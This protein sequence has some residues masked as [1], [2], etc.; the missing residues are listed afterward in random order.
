MKA[1]SLFGVFVMARLL[2]LAGRT[3]PHSAWALPAYL[4]QDA[5]AALCFAA[6]ELAARRQPWL[7]WC[8]YV[9]VVSYVAVNVPIAC[10]LSTPLTWPMLR[11]ARGTLSDS[12]AHHVTVPNLA[13]ML[14]VVGT[15]VALPWL[16][17]RHGPRL[18]TRASLAL[19]AAA[20]V[21]VLIGPFA[22][23]RVATRAG[24]QLPVRPGDNGPA[25][26]GGGGP[27]RGLAPQPLRQPARRRPVRLPRRRGGAQ[28]PHRS[29]RID[30]RRSPASLRRRPR[31]DAATHRTVSTR[32]GL[33]ERLH[34]L[35]R[36]DQEL[37]RRP[38]CRLSGAR[39]AVGGLRARYCTRRW[40]RRWGRPAT[41]P[42]S[43]I[44]GGSA[45]SVWTP[46]S[47]ARDLKRPR[48]R[49]PSAESTIPVSA[50]TSRP[51]SAASCAGSTSVRRANRS[52]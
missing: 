15:A 8:A 39:R 40:R 17:R 19:V 50:S 48:T 35:P 41:T 13:R 36:D 49:G 11:A 5:L 7:A 22:A 12:I 51:P 38:L 2:V 45:T 10:L 42:A 6:L 47:A 18:G 1:V 46:S 24:A 16:L 44:P 27:R 52:S 43:F 23:A 29:S 31:P 25:A 20:L 14:V 28:R 32:H 33:R 3:V 4:W 9:C 34:R 26:G 37:L 30:G 21:L